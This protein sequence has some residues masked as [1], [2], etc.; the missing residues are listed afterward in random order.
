MFIDDDEDDEDDFEFEAVYGKAYSILDNHDGT[1]H[2][3][4]HTLL[5]GKDRTCKSYRG[6]QKS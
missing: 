4:Q 1:E 3:I 2:R 6:V 5:A